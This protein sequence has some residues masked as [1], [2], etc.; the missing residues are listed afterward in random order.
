MKN[1]M[2]YTY[3]FTV[4]Y[5]IDSH[6]LLCPNIADKR[7]VVLNLLFKLECHHLWE[8]R[9]PNVRV[10][11]LRHDSNTSS[12]RYSISLISLREA[13]RTHIGLRY[14]CQCGGLDYTIDQKE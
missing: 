9:F 2:N 8:T 7:A 13:C 10:Y 5:A 6:A 3:Y 12:K 1:N 11:N 14:Y 4:S